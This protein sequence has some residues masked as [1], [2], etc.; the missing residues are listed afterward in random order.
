MFFEEAAAKL[1]ALGANL[2]ELNDAKVFPTNE[3]ISDI[4]KER[5]GFAD[6]KSGKATMK[7]LLNEIPGGLEIMSLT[8]NGN[9]AR[10][11]CVNGRY[12]VVFST[13]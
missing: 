6:L 1:R 3:Q 4:L 7:V 11:V 13:E 9:S 10:L 2:S 12:D 8:L 5:E